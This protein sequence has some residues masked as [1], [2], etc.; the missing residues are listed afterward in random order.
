VEGD[1]VEDDRQWVVQTLCAVSV[2]GGLEG[3]LTATGRCCGITTAH[4]R[5]IT[6]SE[7]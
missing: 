1:L 2:G 5:N 7:C 3:C 6:L 4:L